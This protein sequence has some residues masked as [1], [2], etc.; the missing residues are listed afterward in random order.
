MKTLQSY[1][2]MSLVRLEDNDF[3]ARIVAL[4]LEEHDKG[5]RKT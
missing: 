4:G 1:R 5:T 3:R 2:G